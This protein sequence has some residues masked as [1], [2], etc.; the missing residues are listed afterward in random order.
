MSS[1]DQGKTR[2][3]IGRLNEHK[4]DNAGLKAARESLLTQPSPAETFDVADVP[5]ETLGIADVPAETLDL[6]VV[7]AET[8]GNA[9][10]PAKDAPRPCGPGV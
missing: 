3:A 9:D 5:V 7:P 2:G 6:A 1:E 4:F 8:L 10:V